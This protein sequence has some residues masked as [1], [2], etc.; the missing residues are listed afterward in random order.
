MPKLAVLCYHKNLLQYPKEWIEQYKQSI[1][2]QTYK[3]FTI[4][5]I[6]YGGGQN[7]IF[8]NSLWFSLELPT[9]VHSMNYL[10]DFCFSN[11]YDFVGNTNADD[12][13]TLNRLERQMKY[14]K[15]G[16]EI[17]S[18][19]F[20]LVENGRI[21]NTHR[22]HRMNILEELSHDHNIVCHPCV[23]YSKE[24]WKKHRYK[25]SEIPVEDLKLWKRAIYSSKMIILEDVLC[26]HRIHPQSVCKSD[27]R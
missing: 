13:Y 14:T 24:F 6:D 8:E 2:Q 26:F 16:Y 7:R 27:N 20:S 11:G 18:S 10:L 3:D 17:I 19:N 22:F 4:V 25:P 9:F 21:T 23:I 15:H 5:E 12:W 1:L